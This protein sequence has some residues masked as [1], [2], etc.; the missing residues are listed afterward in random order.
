MGMLVI[1]KDWGV[2]Q[3]K[4]MNGMEESPGKI[5]EE[6]LVHSAF[7]QTLGDEFTF[8]QESNLKFKATSTLELL[9]F[10]GGSYSFDLNLLD[11]YI[12][13]TNL[14]ELEEF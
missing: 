12:Y 11:K 1:I 7:Q 10:L 14:T 5:L 6:N 13:L 9:M 8:Q 4:K 3:D 2:F